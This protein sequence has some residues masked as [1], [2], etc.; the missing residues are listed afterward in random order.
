[1]GS[2]FFVTCPSTPTR[3]PH[4]PRALPYPARQQIPS[5]RCPGT[6]GAHDAPIR[7][8][9]IATRAELGKE[10]VHTRVRVTRVGRLLR[11]QLRIVINRDVAVVP[12]A[13]GLAKRDRTQ[14]VRGLVGG[15]S[16][17]VAT[18]CHRLGSS[19]ST[20]TA[21]LASRGRCPVVHGWAAPPSGPTMTHRIRWNGSGRPYRVRPRMVWRGSSVGLAC[22]CRGDVKSGGC[23][24]LEGYL[25]DGRPLGVV[26]IREHQPLGHALVHWPNRR[27]QHGQERGPHFARHHV[28]VP[29]RVAETEVLGNLTQSVVRLKKRGHAVVRHSLQ[30]NIHGSKTMRT[31]GRSACVSRAC[32]EHPRKCWS[33]KQQSQSELH[34]Q[35]RTSS[36]HAPLQ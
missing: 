8:H 30:G 23:L 14:V 18:R 15:G 21:L 20:G 25:L 35:D 26:A 31:G 24:P 17:L 33:S 13:C 7:L 6:H 2:A 12:A 29:A 5:Y 32:R 22:C 16:S 28:C 9:L 27:V 10:E 19:E 4:S 11:E 1:V 36:G 3:P 34:V